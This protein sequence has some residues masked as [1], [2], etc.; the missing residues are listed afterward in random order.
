MLRRAVVIG[1]MAL[2][3]AV[4][5][6]GAA[7]GQEGETPQ[8]AEPAKKDETPEDSKPKPDSDSANAGQ[9]ALDKATELKLTAKT[10]SDLGE[11]VRLCRTALEKGLDEANT[12]FARTMLA[13]TL[14]QRGTAIADAVL[15]GSPLE[16]RMAQFRRLALSDLEAAVGIA[17]DQP[18][19]LLLI[20]RLNLLPAGD[21]K[22]AREVLDQAIAVEQGDPQTRAK[23]RI[24]RAGLED[25]NEKRLDDLN[26]AVRLAPGDPVAVRARGLVHADMG[27][28]DLALAD[29]DTAIKLEPEHAPTY[30]AKA[31]VL[32]KQEKYEAALAALAEASKVE[33]KSVEPLVQRAR[34]HAMQ[35]KL[36]AALNDLN[37]AYGMEPDNLA[38]LLLR[39]GIYQE[40]EEYDKAMGDVEQILKLSPGLAP[41]VRL[42]AF[43]LADQEKMAEA[44]RLLEE[45]IEDNPDDE[46][47]KLQL[48]MLSTA[49]DRPR[50]AIGIYTRLLEKD[51]D[52]WIALR[53][54]ADAYLSI[55]K[56]AEA[57]ADYERAVKVRPADS[58]ILNNFAWVL[59]TSPR[60]ELRDGKRAI[61]L[62]KKACELTEYKEAHI[63]ST[64]G[65]AYAETGDFMTARKWSAKAVKLGREDQ[66]AQLQEELESYKQKK[67]WRELQQTPEKK[68]P[69]RAEPPPSKPGEETEPEEEPDDEPE[70]LPVETP[71]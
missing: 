40:L 48:A 12:E 16:P 68:D 50:R 1:W 37:K 7:A 38:V 52:D 4:G 28:Y 2:M 64:L 60:D 66:K 14:I 26:E 20:A 3:L 6:L 56:H 49:D 36:Q 65:A 24:T 17:A 22:R 55:G 51:P 29:F 33:P 19:A 61:E 54:R 41:A 42:K 45:F 31:M 27:K 11:V 70:P 63:L 9:E 71:I 5:G 32:T 10:I 58:G 8:P 18:E 67:P 69:P 34:V 30:E 62:A 57:I 43:V 25:D 35:M 21:T 46:Q 39:A 53:G 59:A 44:L 47:A 13:A 15:E 23:A